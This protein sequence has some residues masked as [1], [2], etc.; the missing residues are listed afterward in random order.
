MTDSIGVTVPKHTRL[1]RVAFYIRA[2]AWTQARG[3]AGYARD[4][5]GTWRREAPTRG[6]LRT[7][8]G[9]GGG[10]G[11]RKGLCEERGPRMRRPNCC[12]HH[13]VNNIA[14]W[15]LLN[16]LARDREGH[17]RARIIATSRGS[18]VTLFSWG[19]GL[20]FDDRARMKSPP[21]QEKKIK[22]STSQKKKATDS[23][24]VAPL[25]WVELPPLKSSAFPLS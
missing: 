5:L 19:G 22:Y 16:F 12:G 15:M 3:C 24:W 25:P 18:H 17:G 2:I 6:D 13:A 23:F 10:K 11:S 9:F 7:R 4:V 1:S 21:L 8:F 20:L 14:K